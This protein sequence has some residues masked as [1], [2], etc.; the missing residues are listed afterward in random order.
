MKTIRCGEPTVVITKNEDESQAVVQGLEVLGILKKITKEDVVV[1]TPNWVHQGKPEYGIV[2]G[3]ETLRILIKMVKS[4]QPKR[5][6]IATAPADPDFQ[7]VMKLAGFDKV[8]EEEQVELINLNMPP[9]VRVNLNHTGPVYTHLNQLFEEMTFLISFTQLKIHEE[10][11]MSGAIKNIAMG[12][13]SAEEHG[14]PKKNRGIH[15]DLHGFIVAML[16]K[17]PIDLSIVSASPA[18][19]GTGPNNGVAS[20]TGLVL[21]GTDPVATD[22]IGARLLGFKP[23]A[24]HYLY[25]AGKKGLGCNDYNTIK[26]KGMNM[27]EAEMHFSKCVYG[28]SF[29]LQ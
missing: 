8:I 11:T 19:V 13:P 1:I 23:Q 9:F 14:Y 16:E 12:W 4:R 28:Q 15:N 10:A 26:V 17:L 5:L 27:E 2:V 20:H 24:I 22:T 7:D 21:C 6:V 3:P 18:M 29:N 25:E